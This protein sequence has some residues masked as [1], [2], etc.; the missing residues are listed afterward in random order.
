[1]CG[2]FGIL[3]NLK[4]HNIYKIIIDSLIQ[5]QNRGY[6]STGICILKNTTFEIHKYASTNTMSSIEKLLSLNLNSEENIGL[7]HNRWATHGA[8]NDINA[9]PH[10]SNDSKFVLV[11]NGIIEN[12]LELKNF[13]IN[14]NYTFYSQTDTEVIVNLISYYFN[15][16]NDTFLAIKETINKLEGTYGIIIMNNLENNKLY[17]VRNGSPLLIGYNEDY[18]LITSEQS[19]FCNMVNTY[20]TLNNDDICVIEKGNKITLNTTNHYIEKKV[21]ILKHDLTPFPFKHWTLHLFSFQTP[22]LHIFKIINCF[23]HFN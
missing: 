2:I 11:H 21:N 3:L 19:G 23:H 1:M 7:G 15:K 13:L 16:T 9:H 14:N 4:N 22:I 6:D 20:I 18:A 5:L 17:A 10:I 8:K 12:Y